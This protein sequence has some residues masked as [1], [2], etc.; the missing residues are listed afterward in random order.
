MKTLF[1]NN[2]GNLFSLKK[3]VRVISNRPPQEPSEGSLSSVLLLKRRP[4]W[5]RVGVCPRL[6][7]SPAASFPQTR[8]GLVL[9]AQ[10]S[11]ATATAT[12]PQGRPVRERAGPSLQLRRKQKSKHVEAASGVNGPSGTINLRSSVLPIEK[13]KGF[14]LLM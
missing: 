3:S 2:S 6:R 9:A 13:G 12:H 5:C 8:A 11:T 7:C 10:S 4:H 14:A 1:G